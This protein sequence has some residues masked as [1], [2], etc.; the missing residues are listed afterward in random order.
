MKTGI[1][2]ALLTHYA[3][4]TTS[5]CACWKVSLTSGAVLGVTEHDQDLAIDGLNYVARGGFMPSN[6]ETQT[7]LAVDNL[8]AVGFLDS[9]LIVADDLTSGLWN[10]ALVEVFLVNWQDTSM[11]RDILMTGRLG[12]VSLERNIFKA[13]LRGLSKAYAQLIG[14]IYQPACRATLG[15]MRCG[16]DLGAFTVTGTLATLTHLP[17]STSSC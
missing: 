14:Q 7:R 2:S 4:R 6:F 12:E 1:S 9:E 3:Q 17:S 8:E 11:G 10:F 16:V 13:E 15:D 5:L